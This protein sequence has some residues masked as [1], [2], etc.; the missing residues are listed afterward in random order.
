MQVFASDPVLS[1]RRRSRPN[2]AEQAGGIGPGENKP[3]RPSPRT[4]LR[5]GPT[6]PYNAAQMSNF[7]TNYFELEVKQNAEAPR[8]RTTGGE[9]RRLSLQKQQ[10]MKLPRY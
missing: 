8:Q 3:K 5:N 4:A 10:N 7:S 9:R 1:H 2:A 6:G